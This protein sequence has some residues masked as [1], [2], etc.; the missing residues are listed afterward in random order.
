[1]ASIWNYI[2][3]VILSLWFGA[4]VIHQFSPNWWCRLVRSDLFGLLPHWSFFAP[5]PAHEDTHVVYRDL[6]NGEWCAWIVLTARGNR[7]RWR[8]FWNP[9]RYPRKAANDLINGLRRSGQK[10]EHSPRSIIL[11]NSYVGLLQWVAAQS[12]NPG[13]THRQFAIVTSNGFG[14]ER[15]LDLLFLS[16]S[17]RV[18]H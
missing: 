7:G 16:E 11:S 4:S 1:M 3:A 8:W 14:S 17:H 13:V 2:V 5:N 15:P 12:R 9:N 10:L 18:D 6:Q